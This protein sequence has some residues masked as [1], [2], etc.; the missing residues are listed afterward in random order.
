MRRID[1]DAQRIVS[2]RRGSAAAGKWPVEQAEALA[3]A[4]EQ[5]ESVQSLSLPG[6]G[7]AGP[8]AGP[9]MPALSRWAR[10][11]PL[12]AAGLAAGCTALAAGPQLRQQLASVAIGPSAPAGQG[13]RAESA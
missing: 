12:R 13:S 8:T 4:V 2:D 10:R 11:V 9:H 7:P 3:Q 1:A 5:V 6:Q